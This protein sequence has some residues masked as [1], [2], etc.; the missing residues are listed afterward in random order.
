MST[1]ANV[2]FYDRNTTITIH[3]H[4]DGNKLFDNIQQYLNNKRIVNVIGLNPSKQ[5]CNGFSDLIA[6][7]I[8]DV[9]KDNYI[10]NIYINNNAP[11]N[12]EY[13]IEYFEKTNTINLQ[14]YEIEFN[15]KGWK[16]RTLIKEKRINMNI[17]E[18]KWKCKYQIS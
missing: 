18:E 7:Y 12:H 2:K 13:I 17:I 9:K 3:F 5:I 10:G 16:K 11:T 14:Y 8:H 1:P 15:D 4:H 6:Q